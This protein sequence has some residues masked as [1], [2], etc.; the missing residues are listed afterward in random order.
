MQSL[1]IYTSVNNVLM[2]TK[3][4][5]HGYNPEGYTQGEINGL[6]SRPGYNGGSE[7]INRIYTLGLNVNF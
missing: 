5:F 1:R 2:L 6:N 3:D 4:G 7:P